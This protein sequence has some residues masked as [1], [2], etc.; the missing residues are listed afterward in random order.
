MIPI[1][2]RGSNSKFKQTLKEYGT[3]TTHNG[4]KMS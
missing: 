4:H 3:D 1:R 2:Q